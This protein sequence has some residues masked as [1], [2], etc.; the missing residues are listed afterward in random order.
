MKRV[1]LAVPTAVSR[2]TTRSGSRGHWQ[3]AAAAANHAHRYIVHILRKAAA[4]AVYC[5]DI[6]DV[7]K[8]IA[9][10]AVANK[11]PGYIGE[12]YNPS[13]SFAGGEAATVHFCSQD[14]ADP[15]G[16]YPDW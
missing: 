3:A 1:L 6:F 13:E 11:F 9:A 12:Q 4:A 15:D 16:A 8:Y 7:L 2:T 14:K 5:A 10:A